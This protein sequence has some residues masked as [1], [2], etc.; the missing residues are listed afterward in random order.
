M[1]RPLVYVIYNLLLPF[2]LILGF[3]SF[4]IKGIKRG[5]LARNFRQRFGFFR[6]E[7]LFSN[8]E[9][10]QP[11]LIHAV[12][13]GE[14]LLALKVIEA[15]RSANPG[16]LIVL[17]TTT[18]TGFLVAKEHATDS[19]K[20]IHNPV[21]IPWV[22]ASV[23]RKIRPSALILIEAEIWPNL[24]G[25]LARRE[26]PV[27]LINA[28][29][30]PRSAR[31]YVKFRPFIE[32]IFSQLSA[33]TVPFSSDVARWNA[34]GIP[35][36]RIHILG[37]VKFDS[38]SGS[39]P[40]KEAEL[41][42]WLHSTGMSENSRILLA[43]STHDG[44]ESLI[45]RDYLKL[46]QEIPNLS[47]VI[48]PRHAER[49]GAIVTQLVEMELSTIVKAPIS[50]ELAGIS[51]KDKVPVW[52]ANTTGELRSWFTLAEVVVIGKSF[53]GIGGQ[54]PVEPIL[55]GKPVVVGPHM[56]N[57]ADVVH[58]LCSC[59]GIVQLP[60]ESLLEDTLR[61]LLLD[62]EMG[63][64]IAQRGAK[65]MARH[66]GSAETTAQFILTQISPPPLEGSH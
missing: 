46:R 45:V 15:L 8:D 65:A 38:T 36:D 19:F 6:P 52:I 20:V 37:S 24:V 21:D 28:R 7:D 9:T 10:S 3:P 62:P 43:G 23:I 49:A 16:Q 4:I 53:C 57:F 11:L 56:E 33:V 27:L 54:N 30:S 47:L 66:E 40:G 2:V 64:D 5:G 31:R 42:D 48:V 44:E 63:S 58:D 55:A 51:A 14:V 59:E 26:I 60:D 41:R 13:V 18:T 17:S 32:P 35:E 29:L 25:Q 1:P 50:D 39:Q 34:I 12:S 61:R 22:T